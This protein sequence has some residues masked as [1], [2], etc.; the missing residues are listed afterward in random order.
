MLGKVWGCEGVL[1][2]VRESLLGCEERCGEVLGEVWKSVLG[3]G[4]R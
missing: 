3:C 1:G 2:E 4:G